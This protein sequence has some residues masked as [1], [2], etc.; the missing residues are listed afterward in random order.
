MKRKDYLLYEGM[1]VRAWDMRIYCSKEC[2]RNVNS[3][4]SYKK[5]EWNLSIEHHQKIIDANKYIKGEICGING[6]SN[7][8]E[9]GFVPD[10]ES[11]NIIVEVENLGLITYRNKIKYKDYKSKKRIL[12]ISLTKKLRELFDQIYLL[13][14]DISH[15]SSLNAEPTIARK[16]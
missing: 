14:D 8:N 15:I 7:P 9:F 1:T 3:I 2:E 10:I 12:V 16:I 13:D 11:R 4:R 6:S 5:K